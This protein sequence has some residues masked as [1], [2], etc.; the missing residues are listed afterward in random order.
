MQTLQHD[1]RRNFRHGYK[2]LGLV[3]SLNSDRLIN[4]AT[5]VV[6]LVAGAYLASHL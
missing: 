6:A 4:L 1:S 5:L 2:G 3:L